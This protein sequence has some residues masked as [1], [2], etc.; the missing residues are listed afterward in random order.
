MS[1][2]SKD[3][4]KVLGVNESAGKDEIKSA[5]RK[6]AKKYHPDANADNPKAADRFKEVGEAY[7]VLSDP[8]KRKKYDQMRKLGAFGIGKD[9]GFRTSTAAGWGAR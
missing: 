7:S 4:Y 3:F 9:G 1:N 5:Y 8:A 6:L 2:A